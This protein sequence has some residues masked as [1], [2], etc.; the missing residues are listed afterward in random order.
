[1]L[2]SEQHDDDYLLGG[3]PPL[4]TILI[5]S[6]GPLVSQI[7]HAAANVVGSILVAKS[8]GQVGVEVF[9][10]IFVVEFF[11]V[12]IAHF[13]SAG[14]SVRLSYLYG[15]QQMENCDQLFVDFI[16][17]SIMFGIFVPCLI[18][19]ITKTMVE[20]FGADKLTAEMSL[21]Y[22]IPITGGCVFN[23][24]F[25]VASGVVQA[26]GRSVEYAVYQV[27]SLVLNI[28]IF[29]PVF[30][31][32]IKTPIWGASLATILS[33]AIPGI[34]VTV[35]TFQGKYRITPKFN[36]FFKC[37]TPET[38]HA[39]NIGLSTLISQ[40]SLNLPFLI[41]Q[42]YVNNAAIAINEYGNSVAVWAVVEKLYLIVGGVCIGFSNGFLN[43][44]SY[45]YGAKNIKRM[46][47]LV[48]HGLWLCTF[49][50]AIIS[51]FIIAMPVQISLLWS[52]NE[53]FLEMSKG[54]TPILYYTAFTL[55]VQYMVPVLLQATKKIMASSVLSVLTLVL[56]VPV[57][58]TF[59]YFTGDG[60]RNPKRIFYAYTCN[61]LY[62]LIV[63]ILFA[64]KPIRM[65]YKAIKHGIMEEDE[66]KKSEKP[67]SE[68]NLSIDNTDSMDEQDRAADEL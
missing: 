43:P 61:D 35:R 51:I 10:A 63:C 55:G 49:T 59:L 32:A 39:L 37:F 42:K 5:M 41:M 18:L 62:S 4:V 8:I 3:R 36:M 45:A 13:L 30:L 2:E 67:P 64:I 68:D 23:I 20:W 56:P 50:C 24:I 54:I 34:I 48:V 22:M 58:S 46:C 52:D 26:D 29:A 40:I 12:A 17:I 33:E 7:V 6:L 21:E 16:R 47:R 11:A 15:A 53:T 38:K 60:K 44:G 31:L 27:V 1:M 65:M 28:G 14:L 9:G 19:P 66:E 57:F 25:F